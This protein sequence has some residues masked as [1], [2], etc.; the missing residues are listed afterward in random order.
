MMYDK[1]AM[2]RIKLNFL[3]FLKFL[4]FREILKFLKFSGFLNFLTFLDFL[5]FLKFLKHQHFYMLR[6]A[7]K[8][9]E[10]YGIQLIWKNVVISKVS[11]PSASSAPQY[12]LLELLV[13][14]KNAYIFIVF[15]IQR[16][17]FNECT[18][19]LLCQSFGLTIEKSCQIVIVI[20]LVV[21]GWRFRTSLIMMWR[22]VT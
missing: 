21:T 8:V 11:P 17:P 7:W 16:T 2:L 1:G 20:Q 15:I 22:N 5:Q 10:C 14:L 19:F 12:S 13:A 18:G 9:E 6:N 3:Q 4:D